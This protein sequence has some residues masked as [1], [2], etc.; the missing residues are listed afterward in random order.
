MI[1]S[2]IYSQYRIMSSVKED[3]V[4]T[5]DPAPKPTGATSVPSL[6]RL[7]LDIKPTQLPIIYCTSYD[8][9]FFGFEKL[10]PF[11]TQKWGHIFKFLLEAG[12]LANKAQSVEPLQAIDTELLT[13]HTRRYIDSLSVS[14]NV[15]AIAEIPPVAAIP[16]FLVQKVLL[17]PIRYQVGAKLIKSTV[18]YSLLLQ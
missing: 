2:V 11:D 8:I 18:K 13:H 7:Y 12:I 16:N 3:T 5:T 4:V 10:H 15:A 1:S 6:P 9:S 14:F 17:T